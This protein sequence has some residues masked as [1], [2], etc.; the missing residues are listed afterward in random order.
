MKTK[1]M[2]AIVWVLIAV[3]ITTL[4]IPVNSYAYNVT[5]IGTVTAGQS[6][7]GYNDVYISLPDDR[8]WQIILCDSD[9]PSPSHTIS[10]DYMGMHIQT[11]IV[12]IPPGVSNILSYGTVTITG[13]PTGP[14]TIYIFKKLGNTVDDD[15]RTFTVT[16]GAPGPAG[17]GS[18]SQGSSNSSQSVEGNK[19]P[20][21]PPCNH[22]YEWKTMK[23]ATAEE[24]GE[25]A[26]VC[27][28]CGAVKEKLGLSAMGAFE[29]E[30]AQKILKAGPGA[31]VNIDSTHWNT[32]GRTMKEA[33]LK[34]RDVTVKSSFL[35]EGHK[36]IPLKVTIPAGTDIESL[37]DSNGY[38]GL[39]RVGSE[40]GYDQ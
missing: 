15:V 11:G 34:R 12:Q 22:T 29:E 3:L 19:V 7:T 14:C 16:A 24:D 40:L 27:T 33:M 30:G 8:N 23:E 18:N 36:G 32:F 28:Q 25:E 35:S 1:K 37:Y 31:T 9:D 5:N 21:Q 39:C 26:L 2:R 4:Y 20:E 38:M 17:G 10:D 13:Q 6:I